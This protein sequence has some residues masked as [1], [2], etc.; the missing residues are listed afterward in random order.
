MLHKKLF[1]L[2]SL[3]PMGVLA[4][5]PQP[6]ILPVI[7]VYDGDTIM[8]KLSLPAPLDDIEIRINGIDTAEAPAK[9][10]FTTG[11]LGRA[12]CKKEAELALQAKD[13]VVKL[14]QQHDNT[15]VVKNYSWDKYGSRIDGDVYFGDINVAKKLLS[16]N[17]AI[18]YNGEAKTKNWCE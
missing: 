12:K 6:L 13:I 3:L 2:L 18:V 8:T 11:K 9:S 16:E 4:H 17:L 15:M 5:D 7:S 1:V 14:S 10:Y